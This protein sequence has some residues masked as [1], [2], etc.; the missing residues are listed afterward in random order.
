[1]K[2]FILLSIILSVMCSCDSIEGGGGSSSSSKVVAYVRQG[3]SDYGAVEEPRLMKEFMYYLDHHEFEDKFDCKGFHM[4]DL[5]VFQMSRYNLIR[6]IGKNEVSC[7]KEY[8]V[9][10]AFHDMYCMIKEPEKYINKLTDGPGMDRL[11]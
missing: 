2:N 7:N 10:G 8:M 6:D 3:M 9:L 4:T 1:M 11:Y 5:Y